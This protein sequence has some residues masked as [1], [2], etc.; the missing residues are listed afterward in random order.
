MY[1]AGAYADSLLAALPAVGAEPVAARLEHPALA[2]ARSGAMLLTGRADEAPRLAP[3]PLATCAAAA[4]DALRALAPKSRLALEAAGADAQGLDGAALLGERA[5]YLGLARRG[6][7]SP[8]GSCRLL[9]AADGW[10]AVSLS[11]DEDR[12]L[13]PAWLDG[14]EGSSSDPWA[15]VA[16]RVAQRHVAEVVARARLLGLAVSEA[17]ARV[18]VAPPWLRVPARGA[19]RAA[20]LERSAPLVLDLSALWAG[21]LC[22]RLLALAGARVVK[23]ESL[24]RPDGA[25]YGPPGF[26][27]ALNTDKESL[28]LDLRTPR[29]VGCLRRLLE[30]ADAVIESARPRGLAQLG[31]DAEAMVG[32]GLV[33]VSITGYGRREPESHW[34]AYGDDAAAASGLAAA[35]GDPDAPLFCGDAIADPLTGLHAAVAALAHL[36]AGEGALLELALRDV[37]AHCLGLASVR[38]GACVEAQGF[39]FEVVAGRARAAVSA[40]RA[41]LPTGPARPLGADTAS[42]LA[43]LGIRC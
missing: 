23:V 21:P 15:L 43:E 20:A 16:S 41:V 22:G 26:Y 24:G 11:R 1:P 13:I 18:G 27:A 31:I 10:V 9:R 34:I 38:D 28:A 42:L 7:I 33:W 2:W 3:A 36:R 14:G 19:R 6:A 25:R 39:D 17:G 4:L 8:G 32:E 30:R 40:P 35:T 12:A 29:G 37:T 5:A